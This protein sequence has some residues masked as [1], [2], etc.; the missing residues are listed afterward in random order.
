[1]SNRRLI[2]AL[3]FLILFIGGSSAVFADLNGNASIDYT[4]FQEDR[5]DAS[6]TQNDTQKRLNFYFT[7]P[8][9][10]LL[11]YQLTLRAEISDS[12]SSDSQGADYTSLKEVYEPGIDFSLKNVMYEFDSGFHH[13]DELYSNSGQAYDNKRITDFFYSRFAVSP[14]NL[15]TFSAELSRI[16]E[17]DNIM[18]DRQNSIYFLRSSYEL[19]SPELD[20]RAN[21][22]YS[23]AEE[24]NPGKILYKNVSDAYSGDYQLSDSRIF[25]SGKI[26]LNGSYRGNFSSADSTSYSSDTGYVL[27]ER[28]KL[29]GLHA[30]GTALNPDVDSLPSE[31]AL[32]DDNY[33]LSTSINLSISGSDEYHNIGIW[34]PSDD[35][36]EKL[37]IYVN[38]DVTGD[39]SLK[40]I[41]N[42]KVYK[43]DFNLAGT[44][45]PVTISSVSVSL[46]DLA[47][48]IYRY[49]IE[50]SAPHNA[51]Y[52]KAVNMDVSDISN[53]AVT[54]IE[55]YGSEL[56]PDSGILTSSSNALGQR[57]DFLSVFQPLSKFRFSFNYSIDKSD[58]N[59][60]SVFS[61]I[62]SLFTSIFSKSRSEEDQSDSSS[63]INKGLA[64]N[65]N[66]LTHKFLTT[67][68][69]FQRN[70]SYDN[71]FKTDRAATT[72]E[73]S[74]NS[75][76]I[77][78]LNASFSMVRGD[79]Y[80]F[81]VK[82][83]TYDS[84]IL[85]LGTRLY[86][87]LNM[88]TDIGYSRSDS[89][90]GGDSTSRYISGSIDSVFTDKLE[91]SLSYNINW[92]SS[93]E[94]E[95]QSKSSS[96]KITYRPGRFV[97]LSCDFNYSSNDAG[98]AMSEIITAEW[99]PV[100]VLQLNANYQHSS[101]SSA[102]ITKDVFSGNGT[103]HIKK[104]LHAQLS[105]L[106]EKEGESTE[107]NVSTGMRLLF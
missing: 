45:L 96:A 56:I 30:K 50:F 42:W 52:F 20:F 5:G 7:K 22:N 95:V 100:P 92:K 86:R 72:Y 66:W 81:E 61:S 97:N 53:V 14:L 18:L 105:F 80:Q 102:S 11:S 77:E 13:R 94:S 33:I 65:A 32:A 26:I 75:S 6:I 90:S 60:S 27:F 2:N 73:L 69:R 29:G 62:T 54:E 16:K 71:A 41:S 79:S 39:F 51:R 88:V 4:S 49:E 21:L 43:S 47:N 36:V 83:S 1:M 48:T 25:L 78:T 84:A 63:T 76:P 104:F 99:R 19:P 93:G 89:V 68:F 17:S 55:A 101:T 31:T 46:F 44:W 24:E 15:P 9:T 12:D 67:N 87:D 23:H 103:W 34:V 70:E 91:G 59:P 37:Y 58:Q 40:S 82:E 64:L 98:S 107:Q 8:I 85:S 106:Y 57:L 74:F 10:S 35:S 38:K 3:L 28:T